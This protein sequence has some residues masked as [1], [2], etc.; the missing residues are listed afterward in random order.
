ML[1]LIIVSFIFLAVLMTVFADVVVV[2]PSFVSQTRPFDN[3]HT[4]ITAVQM[5]TMGSPHP[6]KYFFLCQLQLMKKMVDQVFCNC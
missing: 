3:S 6:I 1:C 4:V 5:Y 2:V